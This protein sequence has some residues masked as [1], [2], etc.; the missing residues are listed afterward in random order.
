MNIYAQLMNLLIVFSYNKLK[1][2]NIMLTHIKQKIL[3]YK[4]CHCSI[5]MNHKRIHNF[6]KNAYY[7]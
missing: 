7:Y 3:N 4:K 2:N 6:H 1:L 5:L